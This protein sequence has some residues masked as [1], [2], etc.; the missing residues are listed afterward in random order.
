MVSTTN[1]IG[2]LLQPTAAPAPGDP[3]LNPASF[4]LP[5]FYLQEPAG[6]TGVYDMVYAGDTTQFVAMTVTGDVVLVDASTGPTLGID[7]AV[8]S[9]FNIDCYGVIFIT[10]GGSN[11]TWST[12]GQSCTMVQSSTPANNMKALPV[13]IPGVQDALNNQKRHQDLVDKLLKGTDSEE[14][15]KRQA[16]ASAPTCPNTPAGLLYETK[17]TYVMDTGNFCDNLSDDWSLSPFDFTGSCVIQ[18]LCY[19]QCQD[20]S[21]D[22]CNAIFSYVMLLSCAADFDN[23]WEVAE[24]VACAAQAAYFTG[25]AATSTGRNLY[26]TAQG[27]MCAC[28]CSDPP[29]TCVYSDGSFY[30]ADLH[31]SDN[32]NCGACG[33]QCGANS[34]WLVNLR[35]TSILR[36]SANS[37]L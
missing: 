33:R 36:A 20:F 32:N 11:Y 22:G 8:T 1:S 31:G 25:V 15:A 3:I 34:A 10:Y 17:S 29:E 6:V 18:S 28:F 13:T 19:D 23:W 24:A 4:T 16:G 21:W 37:F 26:D 9:I 30:C 7:L 35:V 2:P 14:L 27:N 5:A 12:D